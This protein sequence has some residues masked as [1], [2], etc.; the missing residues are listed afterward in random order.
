[1]NIK[2]KVTTYLSLFSLLLGGWLVSGCSATNNP[3]K[4][5]NMGVEQF[6]QGNYPKAMGM[7]KWALEKRREFSQPMIGLA[8]CY[9]TLATKGLVKKD[10]TAALKDLEEALYWINQAVNAD[11]GNTQAF[12]TKIAILKTRGQAELAV[13]AARWAARNAGPSASTLIMLAET[14]RELGD[15]DNAELALKQGLSVSENNIELLV[16]LAKLYDQVGKYE[17]SLKYYNL[18]YEV[19]QYYPNLLRRIAQIEA[20]LKQGSQKK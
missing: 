9:L 6:N 13:N 2:Q 12:K 18:A 20:N 3:T 1:M 4:L 5:Y 15:I 10:S 14:Y 16:E 17:M 7:F 11:P 19:D 8:R